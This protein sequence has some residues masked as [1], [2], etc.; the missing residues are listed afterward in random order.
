MRLKAIY[1]S[2]YH[3]LMPYWVYEGQKHYEC[4]YLQHLWINIKYAFRWATF[5]EDESDIEFEK[6]I[7]QQ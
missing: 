1:K 2:I 4:S 3:G 6:E 7:N 5:R